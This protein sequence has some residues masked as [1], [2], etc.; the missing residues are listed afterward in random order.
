MNVFVNDVHQLLTKIE[1]I[2]VQLYG[3]GV[4]GTKGGGRP[5]IDWLDGV[6][7]YA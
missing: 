2:I 3:A 6:K 1:I 7:K 4:D 5:C